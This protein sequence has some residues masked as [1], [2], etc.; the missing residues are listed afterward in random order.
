M[1][2]R[3]DGKGGGVGGGRGRVCHALKRRRKGHCIGGVEKGGL[4]D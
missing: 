1:D 2:W 3:R 4:S